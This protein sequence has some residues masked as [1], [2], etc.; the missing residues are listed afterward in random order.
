MT[1]SLPRPVPLAMPV[2]KPGT[3][4][5]ALGHGRVPSA[6]QL[7]SSHS[8]HP[9]ASNP[10]SRAVSYSSS[11]TTYTSGR[12]G[13]QASAA[14]VAKKASRAR[15]ESFKPRPSMDENWAADVGP[16]GAQR[17]W[18]GF[19]GVSVKEEDEEY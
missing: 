9:Y 11:S 13:T 6:Q 8:Y 19:A 16:G 3:V 2:P 4:H 7:G 5:H 10:S 18:A 15:R 1:S 14:A 17:R 12:Y